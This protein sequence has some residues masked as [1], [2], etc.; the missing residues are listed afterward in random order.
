MKKP[1]AA[2]AASSS[3]SPAT[4]TGGAVS[5]VA[6][7]KGTISRILAEGGGLGA[8]FVGSTARI[9][10]RALSTAITWTL[11]EEAM[12]RGGSGGGG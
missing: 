4:T 6:L 3:V 1:L 9:M 7:S 8:L 5:A 2:E 10:K 12:R 11:F